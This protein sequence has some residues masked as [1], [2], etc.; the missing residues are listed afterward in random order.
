MFKKL[1]DFSYKRNSTE[2]LGFY[3]AYFLLGLIL[4]AISGGLAGALVGSTQAFKAGGLAGLMTSIALCLF[5]SFKIVQKKR[6]FG[7]YKA[8]ILLLLAILLSILG[9]GLL[10]LIPVSILSSM[11]AENDK[12][13]L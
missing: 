10:G 2:S 3:L 8:I 13:L 4:G 1:T 9:G 12:Q 5:L 11:K 7:S 6:L